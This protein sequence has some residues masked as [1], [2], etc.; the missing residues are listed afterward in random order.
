MS[1]AALAVGVL[2]GVLAGGVVATGSSG[3]GG[4]RLPQA[5]AVPPPPA[6]SPSPGFVRLRSSLPL[7]ALALGAGLVAP[8]L[9][10]VVPLTVL[11]HRRRA[12]RARRSSHERAAAAALPEVVD[13]LLLCAGAG[14]AVPLAHPLVAARV[15]PPLCDALLAADAAT[16]GGQARADALLAA[17]LP[18]GD[19]AAALGHVLVDHLRYGVPVVPGLER[20]ALELR[21]DRRRRAEEAARRVPVRMLGPLVTCILPAF[22][23]LTVVPLLAASLRG[24]PT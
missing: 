11:F 22:G 14:V 23:L 8:P 15:P 10:A 24:L 5:A 20:L 3:S 6:R 1:T 19:R 13:L 12:Q 9:L 4:R 2:A 17:L 21:L 16:S 7:A 18:L